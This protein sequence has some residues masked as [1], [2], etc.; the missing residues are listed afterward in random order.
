M[1]L[2]LKT[3]G[4]SLTPSLKELSELK[5]LEP[6]ERRLG[7]QMPEDTPL[8]VELAKITRHHEEGKIWK[9]EINLA[10]PRE[11]RTIYLEIMEE[12][13]EAAINMAKDELERQIGEYKE[14]RTAK[15]L[16][17]ARKLKDSVHVASLANKAKGVFK[18]FRRK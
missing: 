9:C 16:R 13:I 2:R 6:V 15:F 17:S 1:Q 5:L 14:K 10:L 18:W 12:S 8:D 11:K 7:S 4:F 3:S